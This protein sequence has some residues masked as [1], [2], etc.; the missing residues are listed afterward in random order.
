MD[1]AWSNPLIS[2]L[3]MLQAHE[4]PNEICFLRSP[5]DE[6][7]VHVVDKLQ[8]PYC[9]NGSPVVETNYDMQSN[10]IV[11][12]FQCSQFISK[13]GNKLLPKAETARKPGFVK[14]NNSRLTFN[15]ASHLPAEMLCDAG[16]VGTFNLLWHAKYL[17][18]L[19]KKKVKDSKADTEVLSKPFKLKDFV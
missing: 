11:F 12:Q 13:Y 14:Q 3:R 2:C 18:L 9:L 16:V 8:C 15:D 4:D 7:T 5:S 10:E 6:F 19:Q 1:R 17:I